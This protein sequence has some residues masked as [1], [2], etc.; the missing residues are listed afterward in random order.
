MDEKE[1]LRGRLHDLAG[2]AWRNGYPA[3]SDFLSLA[4]Q[5]LLYAEMRKE[6]PGADEHHLE[7]AVC[8]LY[9]GFDDAERKCAVFLP[10][11]LTEADFLSGERQNPEVIACLYIS[12]LNQEFSDR[13]TH[14]DYLGALMNM[15]IERGK[16][17]DILVKEEGAHVVVMKEMAEYIGRELTRVRRTSVR[18]VPVSFEEFDVHPETEIRRGS[19]SSERLDSIAAMVWHL[20]RTT[21][22]ELAEQEKMSV[23]GRL[24]TSSSHPLHTG[25]RVSLRGYG[26]FVYDGVV[27]RTKKDRLMVQVSVYV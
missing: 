14:R 23:N 24:I 3:H 22:K 7:G 17:G 13:P 25:D 15:G 11:Y 8:L 1:Y 9:G 5:E 2:R 27:S 16:V 26:K 21:A 6:N 4:E 19:V 18:A 10:E 20:S 12:P